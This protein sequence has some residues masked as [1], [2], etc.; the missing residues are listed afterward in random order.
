MKK[1]LQ[2]LSILLFSLPLCSCGGCNHNYTDTV[3][4]PT[5]TKD[6]YTLHEC[7]KCGHHFED[8]F[9]S[10]L[11]HSYSIFIYETDTLE[12]ASGEE[13]HQ[14]SRCGKTNSTSVS[15]I[16]DINHGVRSIS[17]KGWDY[18]LEAKY[19]DFAV[20]LT[21]KAKNLTSFSG[22][23]YYTFDANYG[24]FVDQTFKLSFNS[25]GISTTHAFGKSDYTS[26]VTGYNSVEASA[27][28]D[29]SYSQLILINIPYQKYGISNKEEAINKFAFYPEID[30]FIYESKNPYVIQQYSE[31]W[32]KLNAQNKLWYSTEF[33]NNVV[34]DWQRADLTSAETN[35]AYSISETTIQRTIV[36]GLIAQKKGAAL[37]D[38]HI[39]GLGEDYWNLESLEFL[40]HSFTIPTLALCYNGSL[41][42]EVRLNNLELAA[43]AGASGVD[44][45]GFMYHI[46]DT[47]QTQTPENITYW[48]ARGY[49]MSFISS[50]PKE[51]V[52]DPEEDAK[53]VSYIQKI[54]NI[55]AKV[56][57]S[58]HVQAF[59]NRT[60]AKAFAKFLDRRGLDVIKLV[61]YGYNYNNLVD[62]IMSNVDMHKDN[63]IHA[64]FSNH[65]GNDSRLDI[66][67]VI[68]PLFYHTYMCF[69]YYSS[70]HL[71]MMMDFLHSGIT[72]DDTLSIEEA[73]YALR[74]KTRDP[75]YEWY[76]SEFE[77]IDTFE[78]GAYGS[79]SDM[80]NRWT[81]KNT[82]SSIQLRDESGTNS[83]PIRGFSYDG[84]NRGSSFT[85]ETTISGFMKPYSSS[86]RTPK[87][88][89]F[90][91]DKNHMLAFTYNYKKTSGNPDYSFGIWTN[92]APMSTGSADQIN[93]SLITS[94]SISDDLNSGN[95]IKLKVI[96][97]DGDVSF[98]YSTESTENEYVLFT[99]FEYTNISS[100]FTH[101]LETKETFVGNMFEV[102]MGSDSIGAVNYINYTN[103]FKKD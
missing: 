20:F 15:P 76:I 85:F 56:V 27:P 52:I 6:G 83:F 58:N 47:K 8:N 32:I 72:F 25:E 49:D 39:E 69:S 28:E 67:R 19:E 43:R 63:T 35:F 96:Y 73:I 89:L 98:Y 81:N 88:G 3:I 36:A 75:D 94:T 45:Q 82:N 62:C 51:T 53:Q 17:L 57:G 50:G 84:V 91:G 103:S 42:Q 97:I 37:L 4:N 24:R 80:S 1:I 64:K 12:G 71:Q 90:I 55:G 26:F 22:Y 31:T 102:Y 78:Y 60:Q 30:N 68:G 5:C 21:V 38:I 2:L 7:S 13:Y 54:H 66:S 29:S 9:V 11:G 100:Y 48:E 40:F 70:C 41:S 99:S 18:V 34:E 10:K 93:T 16:N 77:K 65:T 33:Q 61:S 101:D 87:V 79:S 95:S 92:S 46:G 74:G 86:T 59:F 14:C 44:L 23:I